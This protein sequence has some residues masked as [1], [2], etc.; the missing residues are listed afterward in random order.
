MGLLPATFRVTSTRT[1]QVEGARCQATRGRA[2]RSGSAERAAT[3]EFRRSR[4]VFEDTVTGLA[5][6]GSDELTHAEM[7]DLL[8]VVAR[9]LMLALYQDQ[10]DLRAVRE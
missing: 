9:D 10:L 3:E 6:P 2:G 4:Q 1:Q 8:T 7:E 5:D